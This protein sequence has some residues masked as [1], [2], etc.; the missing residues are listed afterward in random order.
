MASKF[1]PRWQ[2]SWLSSWLTKIKSGLHWL[3]QKIRQHPIATG[4]VV[5]FI[6]LAAF[7]FLV[8]RFD[9]NWTG[10]NGGFSKTT[11]TS[12][13]HGIT[14]TTEQPQTRTLWDW[15][16]LLLVPILLAIGGFWLNQIQKRREEQTIEQR[17]KLERE[18]AR[19]NQ[20]EN[21]LQAYI[22]K[23]SELILKEHLGELTTDGKL[24]SEYEQVRKI[25]R[26]RTITVLTQLDA[27]RIGYVFAF[28]REA[29][30]ISTILTD[31]VVSLKS[32]NL[33]GV[34]WSHADLWSVSLEAAN[35]E[36]ADLSFAALVDANLSHANLSHAN[37]SY[38]HLWSANLSHAYLEN[39]DLRFARLSGADLS[40]A[41]LSGADLE[42]AIGVTVKELEKQAASLK[43]ATMPTGEV[44]S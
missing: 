10:F 1:G 19:N 3:W 2:K 11:T 34:N 43:G 22:D 21:I 9:W 17:A 40:R 35:L 33:R 37:L 13:T 24:K 41:L 36:N 38:A 30:L 29:K 32:A 42:G 26:V 20:A 12:T 6:A 16:Q 5:A 23:I 44:H 14:T 39:A 28:L 18:L 15:L 25:A 4:I 27:R 8:N 7:A 31:H